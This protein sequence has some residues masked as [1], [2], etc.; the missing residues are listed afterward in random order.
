MSPSRITDTLAVLK[1]Q[2][3]LLGNANLHK[4][5]CEYTK[6]HQWARCIL[7][8][9]TKLVLWIDL[10]KYARRERMDIHISSYHRFMLISSSAEQLGALIKFSP[11]CKRASL[12]TWAG[13]G[14]YSFAVLQKVRLCSVI[15]ELLTTQIG[16]CGLSAFATAV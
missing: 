8:A 15:T 14:T 3:G 10:N 16:Y 7:I 6:D 13:A 9:R 2:V 1:R 11:R 4:Q 5:K 12:A